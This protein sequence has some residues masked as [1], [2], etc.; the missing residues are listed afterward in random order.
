MFARHASPTLRQTSAS[1]SRGKAIQ[2]LR[3]T[4]PV[5]SDIRA[6]PLYAQLR[7]LQSSS[8]APAMEN[9]TKIKFSAGADTTS[10][11]EALQKLLKSAENGGR[12]ALIPSGQGLER[13]FKFKNFTKTWVSLR[14]LYCGSAVDIRHLCCLGQDNHPEWHQ[15]DVET[16]YEPILLLVAD[17]INIRQ[18]S[19]QNW[20]A[21]RRIS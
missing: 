2:I 3:M 7:L 6:S 4:K 8:A 18:V 9:N 11:T 19:L 5:V 15:C 10:L 1:V 17:G 20:Q 16:V 21:V 14:K 13:S 12:W